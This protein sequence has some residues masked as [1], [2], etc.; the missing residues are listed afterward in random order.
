MITYP[1]YH[2]GLQPPWDLLER[3]QN[4]AQTDLKVPAV[5]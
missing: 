4:E 3:Q 5:H 2:G 1:D